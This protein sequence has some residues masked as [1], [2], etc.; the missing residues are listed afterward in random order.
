MGIGEDMKNFGDKVAG[1]AKEAWGQATDNEKLEAEGKVQQTKGE[2]GEKVE[3]AKDN[4]ADVMDKA[5]DKLR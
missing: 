5:E 4:V 1:N 3:G 2:V